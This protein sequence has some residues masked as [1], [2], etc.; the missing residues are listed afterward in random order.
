MWFPSTYA[1][2]VLIQFRGYYYS[3]HCIYCK[4]RVQCIYFGHKTTTISSD[5]T[6]NFEFQWC[7]WKTT[8]ISFCNLL[9]WEMNW[10]FMW[11][12]FICI[13]VEVHLKVEL[14]IACH[15]RFVLWRSHL[16]HQIIMLYFTMD[17]DVEQKNHWPLLTNQPWTSCMWSC[18]NGQCC[19]G[20]CCTESP[21]D[22]KNDKRATGTLATV[23]QELDLKKWQPRSE[24]AEAE[25]SWWSLGH[26]ASS[27]FWK[28]SS[29]AWLLDPSEVTVI[30]MSDLSLL[31]VTT[32]P[33]CPFNPQLNDV[34]SSQSWNFQS[35]GY[36]PNGWNKSMQLHLLLSTNLPG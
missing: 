25:S 29:S 6:D 5:S 26:H 2:Q 28:P 12:H 23:S 17:Q 11:N 1:V 10:F 22:W 30:P 21:R 27:D 9:F 16:P 13:S 8:D 35:P 32:E 33:V 18:Q 20:Q 7:S 24:I 36:I 31:T 4:K 34:I 15:E 19:T 3:S 14:R